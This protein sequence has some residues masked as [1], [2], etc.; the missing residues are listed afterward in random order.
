LRRP[1]G[2]G[3]RFLTVAEQAEI[4]KSEAQNGHGE[5][6]VGNDRPHADEPDHLLSPVSRAPLDGAEQTDDTTAEVGSTLPYSANPFVLDDLYPNPQST[7]EGS[8][9]TLRPPAGDDYGN[10]AGER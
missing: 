7:S 6:S 3:G 9:E 8:D 10:D 5:G 4:R 1:R 2:P